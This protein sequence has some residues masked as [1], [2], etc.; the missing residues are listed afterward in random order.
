MR[1]VFIR[2][3]HFD[4]GT[5]RKRGALTADGERQAVAAGD[6]LRQ[7]GIV[8]DFVCTTNALRTQQTARLVLAA[9][10]LAELPIHPQNGGGF[11]IAGKNL[12]AKIAEWRACLAQDAA[13]DAGVRRARRFA[14]RMSQSGAG[15]RAAGGDARRRGGVRARGVWGVA[16]RAVVWREC[17]VKGSDSDILTRFNGTLNVGD[18]LELT[19]RST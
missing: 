13:R 9:M 6:F 2:H 12:A 5:D 15:A 4:P 18:G 17:A 11:T 1:F 16:G 19:L 7:G 10:G 14:K 8:P 3:G